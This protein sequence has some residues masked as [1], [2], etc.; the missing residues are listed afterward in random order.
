MLI[1]CLNHLVSLIWAATIGLRIAT[2][3]I[4]FAKDYYICCYTWQ[5]RP[6][7]LTRFNPEMMGIFN[8]CFDGDQQI[9]SIDDSNFFQWYGHHSWF[10]S[11]WLFSKSTNHRRANG[12]SWSIC[13]QIHLR[14]QGWR[15]LCLHAYFFWRKKC[16]QLGIKKCM[17]CIMEVDA[18]Q[19]SNSQLFLC[20]SFFSFFVENVKSVEISFSSFFK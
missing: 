3:S 19:K 16:W 14:E 15:L 18:V 5:Y 17:E 8:R 4:S 6:F 20:F 7:F 10:A 9:S 12:I 11:K 13:L 2:I 1:F